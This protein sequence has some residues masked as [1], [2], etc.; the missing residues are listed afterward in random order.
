MVSIIIVSYNTRYKTRKCLE[1]IKQHLDLMDHEVIVVDNGSNDGS[2]DMIDIEFPFVRLI[3]N[4]TNDGF[5]IANNQGLSISKGQYILF[6]NSDTEIINP[7]TT[8]RL[9]QF[10]KEF[11]EAGAIVPKLLNTDHS[12]QDSVF[13]F[14]TL[15][16]AFKQYWLGKPGLYGPYAPEDTFPCKIEAAVMA[17][18]LVPRETI[19]LVG[20]LDEKYF[21]YFEDIDYCERIW[22]QGKKIYYLP[23]ISIIHH[24]GESG[25]NEKSIEQQWQRLI[26][27]SIKYHGRLKHYLI[28]FILWSGQKMGNK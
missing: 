8:Y 21:M 16:R 26:P 1:S 20:K 14:P 15:S 5:A 7:L 27:S 10:A 23:D 25:K 24:L 18:M 11:P 22:K 3:K 13:K 19:E 2:A 12:V 28:N 17:A 4:K 9:V 6:L